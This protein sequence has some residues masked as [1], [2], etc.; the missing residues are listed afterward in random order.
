MLDDI[1]A[2]IFALKARLIEL[3]LAP[4]KLAI[5]GESADGHLTLLYGC[6]RFEQSPIPI[7]LPRLC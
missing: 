7:W 4:R 1:D 6:S 5:T 2:A 3:G